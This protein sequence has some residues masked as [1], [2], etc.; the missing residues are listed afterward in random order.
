[1]RRTTR[2]A[3][4]TLLASGVALSIVSFRLAS[5]ERARAQAAAVATA[6][7]EREAH[8]AEELRAIERRARQ[9][10]AIEP[11]AAAV[12][13]NVDADTL[14][15]L[16][17]NE[18]WWQPYR[19]EFSFARLIVDGTVVAS[20]GIADLG[21]LD[22]PV[23]KLARR[24]G[25]ASQAISI[26]SRPYL[27]AAA[28]LPIQ[29]ERPPIVVLGREPTPLA[30]PAQVAAVPSPLRSW[31]FVA[32]GLMTLVG[33]TLLMVRGRAPPPM[34]SA[35][36]QDEATLPRLVSQTESG[37][38][39][40][41]AAVSTNAVPMLGRYRLLN[42]LGEGGMAEL[43]LAEV[44]GVEGFS[45]TFVLKR[46]RPALAGEKD[47][48]AQFVD[49][50]R[51]QASL[52]HSNIVPV[53][54]FGMVGSQY[55]MTQEYIVGR[56]LA[57]LMARYQERG[58]RGLPP[59]IARFIAC[60][61][62]QALAY[63]HDSRD[64]TGVPMEIVHRDV[65]AG[66]VMISF[67]GEVKLSD[68]GIVKSNRRVSKTQVGMVKG[69]ANFM[70]PE[71]AQGHAVDGR[72]DLFSTGLLLYYCLTGELLYWGDNDLEVLHRA[73][74]G[75]TADDFAGLLG[76]PEPTGTILAK[77]LAL[78]PSDRFQSASEFGD[79]LAADGGAGAGK[80]ALSR[81]MQELFAEEIQ[82]QTA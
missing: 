40:A 37:Q 67:Q 69:N 64:R 14:I 80:H 77:A 39:A 30:V 55:F 18:D 19:A 34:A 4:A 10:A 66:N 68:F 6:A 57:R 7:L 79:A 29:P 56:D 70:S 74:L 36:G 58:G 38:L 42:R 73:A 24:Q 25:V 52:V 49:E 53:F 43:F 15:D 9:A 82:R 47:A 13:M 62:L 65:S 48:I 20:R 71:Q 44:S 5:R 51:L 33:V 50:A 12:K 11:L 3:G 45:R 75:P 2:L 61:V 35:R 41:A 46:L 60:E 23:V 78:E 59:S 28:R 21:N 16:F 27:L 8:D 63:A 81:L 54:D 26:G 31:P 22:R 32:A 76:L 17:D 72:S 1:L